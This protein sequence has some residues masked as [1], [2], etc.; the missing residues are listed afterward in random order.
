MKGVT[1]KLSVKNGSN[2]KFYK[3][4]TV[5]YALRDGVAAEIDRLLNEGIIKKVS[6]SD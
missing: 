2:P 6:Y 1:V 4:R 3:P 5:P